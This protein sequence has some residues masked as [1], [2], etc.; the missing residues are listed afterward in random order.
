MFWFGGERDIEV[1]Q[2]RR[3]EI[4]SR[5]VGQ[6]MGCYAGEQLTGRAAWPNRAQL[7]TRPDPA[8]LWAENRILI[9]NSS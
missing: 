4:T 7:P 1:G 5:R 6:C 9:P 8:H 3:A 2:G